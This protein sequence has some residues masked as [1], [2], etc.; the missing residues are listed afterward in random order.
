M[1]DS[2]EQ[3]LITSRGKACKK[4]WWPKFGPNE[5]KSGPKLGFCVI[6]LKFDPFVFVEIA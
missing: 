1:D 5:P 4:N 2:L 3:C 6:F